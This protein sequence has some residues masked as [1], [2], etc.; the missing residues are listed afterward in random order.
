MSS[1][2]TLPDKLKEKPKKPKG[3]RRKLRFDLSFDGYNYSGWQFH[4]NK[5]KPAVYTI[6]AAAWGKAT[7]ESGKSFGPVAAARLD[8]GVSADH[9]ICSVRT[10][11]NW[12]N[13]DLRELLD[14]VN[15]FLPS[16]IRCLYIAPVP[17][18]FHAIN[19]PK[20]K[21]YGYTVRGISEETIGTVDSNDSIRCWNR[22]GLIIDPNLT[23]KALKQYVGTH[24]F[25]RFTSS[26]GPWKDSSTSEDVTP[27]RSAVRIIFAVSL[28]ELSNGRLHITI[29]GNRFMQHMVRRMVAVAIAVGTGEL[30]MS[31]LVTALGR[32]AEKWNN[33]HIRLPRPWR[34]FC[35]PTVGLCLEKIMLEE[36]LEPVG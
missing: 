34:T 4:P 32:D 26:D 28:T 6:V 25:R 15:S 16:D 3:K 12:T 14:L 19:S 30:M 33:T 24:D 8:A 20:W 36:F 27:T 31:D 18:K 2:S 1:L 17:I 5:K 7:N 29:K 23:L 9:Q 10:H 13:D 35:A 22:K 21:R 11:K